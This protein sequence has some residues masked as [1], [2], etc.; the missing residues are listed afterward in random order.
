MKRSPHRSPAAAGYRP[1]RT[2]ELLPWISAVE[3]LLAVSCSTSRCTRSCP[4]RPPIRAL[5]SPFPPANK[6][7]PP[8]S[9]NA[10]GVTGPGL[11]RGSSRG[12]IGFER[13][14][15]ACRDEYMAVA[16]SSCWYFLKARCESDGWRRC[17]EPGEGERR[18]E[19]ELPGPWA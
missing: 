19:L 9:S 14:E 5:P 8:C 4:S 6:Y 13:G 3:V 12:E 2:G 1:P 17:M 7:P 11:P 18:L 15:V 16:I 10:S